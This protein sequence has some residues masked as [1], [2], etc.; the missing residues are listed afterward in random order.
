MTIQNEIKLVKKQGTEWN[1]NGFGTSSAVWVVKGHEHIEVLKLGSG[2]T[3]ID[4]DTNSRLISSQSSRID[5]VE[6]L[7]HKI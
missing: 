5:A 6:I 1:G 4:R 2:W 3:A 7:S